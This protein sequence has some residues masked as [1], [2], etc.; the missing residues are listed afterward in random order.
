MPIAARSAHCRIAARWHIAKAISHE[1]NL[2]MSQMRSPFARSRVAQ[3]HTSTIV[4][5]CRSRAMRTSSAV[6]GFATNCAANFDDALLLVVVV[7]AVAAVAVVVV[8]D[9]VGK[10]DDC[11]VVEI[12]GVKFDDETKN[13][14]QS[15]KRKHRCVCL[16]T[17][18]LCLRIV[19]GVVEDDAAVCRFARGIGNG[20]Y[21]IG[22]S[23]GAGSGGES[24]RR[25]LSSGAGGIELQL[26]DSE[27]I[28]CCCLV[29]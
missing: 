3:R 8:V 4:S 2:N 26:S 17:T 25:S 13:R 1:S 15:I 29:V 10:V 20:S 22:A 21:N 28:C 6:V 16:P 19:D 24:R 12:G 27:R 11:V 7:V 5:N 23:S 14:T 9:D 18:P